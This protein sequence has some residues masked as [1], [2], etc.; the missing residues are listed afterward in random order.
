MNSM[1]DAFAIFNE[2]LTQAAEE[3]G[4]MDFTPYLVM[5]GWTFLRSAGMPALDYLRDP[6]TGENILNLIGVSRQL[7]RDGLESPGGFLEES[8]LNT[9]AWR[10]TAPLPEPLRSQVRE[11]RRAQQQPDA[12][13]IPLTP[14]EQATLGQIANAITSMAEQPLPDT[15][16]VEAM[17]NAAVDMLRQIGGPGLQIQF[18]DPNTG[19]ITDNLSERVDS[20][21]R[22]LLR[23]NPATPRRVRQR[24]QS[25]QTA[26]APA[27]P[28]QPKPVEE[29]PLSRRFNY[30][31]RE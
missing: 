16:E 30:D 19:Q 18:A 7:V 21:R 13:P 25:S 29:A 11:Y 3:S 9:T 8:I 10:R 6:V 15:T 14:A 1:P 28:D 26:P 23:V 4:Q 27:K 20:R 17:E 2:A 22:P 24:R 31:D 5:R 12:A